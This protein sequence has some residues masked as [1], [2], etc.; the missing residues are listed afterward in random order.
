MT[1]SIE[2]K[3]ALIR[4]PWS[5]SFRMLSTNNVPARVVDL[6]VLY[7]NWYSVSRLCFFVS[8]VLR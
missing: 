3:A 5:T 7:P 8:Q 2:I 1:Q 6:L 4:F